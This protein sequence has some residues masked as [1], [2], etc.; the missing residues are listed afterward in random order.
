MTKD[1]DS[2]NYNDYI[3]NIIN[4]RNNMINNNKLLMME[5]ENSNKVKKWPQ[6]TNMDCFWDCHPFDTQPFGLPIKNLIIFY[7][8]M[9][10]FVVL[11]VQQLIIL[12]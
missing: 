4:E 1:I 8:C 6:K 11:N 12:A 5:F 2:S 9:V 3:K 7:T 10:I